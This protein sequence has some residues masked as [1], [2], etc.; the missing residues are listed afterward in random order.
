MYYPYQI[1]SVLDELFRN[2]ITY[3][4][5]R[6]SSLVKYCFCIWEMNSRSCVEN[7]VNNTV[8]PDACIDLIIDFSNNEMY[9][10]GFSKD[11]R[12]I[13][14]TGNIDFLG[15]RFK[16]GAFFTLFNI[17]ADQVMDN[18]VNFTDIDSANI[19]ELFKTDNTKQRLKIL[20]NYIL[21]KISKIS[22]N[23]AHYIEFVDELY[24]DLSDEMIDN[25]SPNK[26]SKT[27][28]RH[29][30]KIYGLTP[31][32]LTNILRLHFVMNVLFA[33]NKT[34][35]EIA[36]DCGFYDQSHFIKEIKKYTSVSPV[37][38]LYKYNK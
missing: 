32:N 37:A 17:S 23:N 21:D 15:I 25:L 9:F 38:L 3:K 33:G 13:E 20:E 16:P 8:I 18:L 27:I 11:T 6:I 22:D 24:S 1:P 7:T 28:Y 12:S 14:L 5:H 10:S 29:A 4:E 36:N 2:N 30:K 19:D 26:S 35:L 34:L 31:K